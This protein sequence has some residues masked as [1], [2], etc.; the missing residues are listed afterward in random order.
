MLNTIINNT[1]D[2]HQ[3]DKNNIKHYIF[4]DKN[5]DFKYITRKLI[6][7]KINNKVN[8]QD[9]LNI[10]KKYDFNYYDIELVNNY[11][12]YNMAVNII[13]NHIFW[14][15][16]NNFITT[17]YRNFTLKNKYYICKCKYIK[18]KNLIE[19]IKF[20]ITDKEKK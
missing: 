8:I 4:I 13:K 14:S 7:I 15:N 3:I 5:D 6:N 16:N 10:S 17:N 1:L 18:T 20:I 12:K 2:F 19:V 9:I 11:N